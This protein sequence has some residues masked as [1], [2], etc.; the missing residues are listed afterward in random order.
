[1]TKDDAILSPIAISG[2]TCY[3]FRRELLRDI[4]GEIQP[5]LHKHKDEVAHYADIPLSPDRDIYF[6]ME[7]LGMLRLFTARPSASVLVGYAAF[8]VRPALHYSTSVQANQDVLF[9]TPG[10]RGF[11]RKFIEWCD[12]QLRHEGVQ[13]VTQHTKVNP[14]L[15][16]GP[17]LRRIG[18]ECVDEIWA[19]RLDK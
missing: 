5:L 7:E 2:G 13:V 16:F 10:H 19:R 3:Q 12:S 15:N 1:M 11:G 9:I 4:W 14:R 6:K 17:M 8:F 18:Y